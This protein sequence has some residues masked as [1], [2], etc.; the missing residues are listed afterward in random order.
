MTIPFVIDNQQHKLADVLNDLMRY[1]KSHLLD[2][3]TAY[4]N[5]GGWKLLCDGLNGLGN[6]RLLLGGEPEAGSERKCK[7]YSIR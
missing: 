1:H 6:F 3:A 2:I 4:F 5:A 7:I